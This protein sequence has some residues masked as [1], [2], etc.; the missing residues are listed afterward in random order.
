MVEATFTR[1]FHN[2][3]EDVIRGLRIMQPVSSEAKEKIEDVINYLDKR[4]I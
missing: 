4:R 2:D 1:L 3:V